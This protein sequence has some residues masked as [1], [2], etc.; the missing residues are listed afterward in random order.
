M[1]RTVKHFFS[2][3]GRI[4]ADTHLWC[5]SV[6]CGAILLCISFF[7]E[8][9]QRRFVI[10]N[11][12]TRSVASQIVIEYSSVL[13][14]I[15]SLESLGREDAEEIVEAIPDHNDDDEIDIGMIDDAIL[16]DASGFYEY[17]ESIKDISFAGV[18]I[19]NTYSIEDIDALERLVQCE[20][21]GED[22][23]GRILVA[24]V[25]LNRVESGLWGDDI[26]SVIEAPGQFPPVSNGAVKVVDVDDD[27]KE[28]VMS[29]LLGSD[30]SHGAI[31]FQKS[32]AKVWGDKE[33]LFRHGGHSFYR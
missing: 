26:Q 1:F 20:A 29:A 27:T 28:A 9:S 25:V 13:G 7:M 12:D 10:L 24:D 14:S 18:D 8:P 19:S 22:I 21:C 32:A 16:D 2:I 5:I 4:N 33:Y 23:D 6:L 11:D 17:A 31:Y 15:S 3:L 30:N